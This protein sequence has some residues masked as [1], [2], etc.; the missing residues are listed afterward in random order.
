MDYEFSPG[1]IVTAVNRSS[2]PLAW[3]F[4]GVPFTLRPNERRPMNTVY[5]LAGIRQNPIMGTYRPGFEHQH[6]SLIGVV[7]HEDVWP[8]TPAEQTTN[9]EAF[10]RSLLPEDRQNAVIQKVGWSPEEH[11]LAGRAPFSENA[12]FRR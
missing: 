9:P 4:N 7:E 2:K 5:V 1:E 12:E 8:T 3:R 11:A 10:D 6:Q